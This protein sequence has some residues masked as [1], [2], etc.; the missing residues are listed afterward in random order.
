MNAQFL[1]AEAARF[2]EMA[3]GVT[4]REAS[5]QRL[6][7]MAIDYEA[8]AKAADAAQPIGPKPEPVVEPDPEP[9]SAPVSS[10]PVKLRVSKRTPFRG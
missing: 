9:Q 6:L 2:R 8:R 1:R 5:R 3:D 4:D 7:N 10:E